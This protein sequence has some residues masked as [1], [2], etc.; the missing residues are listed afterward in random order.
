M[1]SAK[2]EN[3]GRHLV[4]AR[5]VLALPQLVLQTFPSTCSGPRRGNEF[6]Y[7]FRRDWD[8]SS[9]LGRSDNTARFTP[10][11]YLARQEILG[12]SLT[13]IEQ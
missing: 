9:L 6:S 4:L 5:N 7:G 11:D 8:H 2:A 13:P 10:F 3:V 1:T 12:S